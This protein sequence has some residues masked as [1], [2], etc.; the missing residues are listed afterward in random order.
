MNAL[1]ERMRIVGIALT[2]LSLCIFGGCTK[3]GSDSEP[4]TSACSTIGLT[5]KNLFPKIINGTQCSTD[6]SPVVSL[7]I[8][9]E[10]NGI[11][12]CSGTLITNSVILTAGHC[13]LSLE[14]KIKKIEAVIE[15]I[16]REVS[17]FLPHPQYS[18][19]QNDV[20]LVFLKSPVSAPTLPIVLSESVE[21]GDIISVYGYGLTENQDAGALRSGEMEVTGITSQNI[22]AKFDG[23][24]SDVCNGD[25]GGPAVM[26][27]TQNGSSRPGIVGVTSNGTSD[28]CQ[29]GD[30]SGFANMQGSSIL[31]FV[32]DNA[33]GVEII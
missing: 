30:V 14:S 16:T 22:I 15:G 12:I 27:T 1:E 33:P 2:V 25:S 19:P 32:Q 18:F 17:S 28:K 23:V 10:N 20:G 29:E 5:K 26:V 11:G 31:S 6:N 9:L 13:V 8:L 4:G 7:T 24:G 3:S 21:P